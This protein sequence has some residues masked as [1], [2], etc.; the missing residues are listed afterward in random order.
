MY[1]QGRR[2]YRSAQRWEYPQAAGRSASPGSAVASSRPW[3]STS[4]PTSVSC[5]SSA[6][7]LDDPEAGPCGRCA[8]CAGP[9]LP[10]EEVDAALVEAA[11]AFLRRRHL[12]IEPRRQWPSGLP[13]PSLR[14]F[15]L[16]GRQG[17]GTMGGPG[18]RRVGACSASTARAASTTTW[19]T[20]LAAMIRDWRPDPDAHLAH[21]RARLRRRRARWPTSPPVWPQHSGIPGVDA[22]AKLRPTRPSRSP[23][24]TSHQQVANLQG[25]FAVR[26]GA[27]RA[28]APPRRHGRFALDLTVV[29]S[30]LREAGSGPVYPVALADTSRGDQ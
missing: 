6:H 1:R 4:P 22:V 8:N 5:T 28:R 23:C 30:L 27:P 19:W 12:S 14:E 16:R 9:A 29:G 2:W 25:A 17:A 11:L 18:A 13:G 10:A 21:F 26:R 20:S 24:R 15:G 3:S 7:Q